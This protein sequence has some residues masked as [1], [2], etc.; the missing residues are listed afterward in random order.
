M[1]WHSHYAGES[2]PTASALYA[3]LF[4][5]TSTSSGLN[6]SLSLHF[7]LLHASLILFTWIQIQCIL[8]NNARHNDFRHNHTPNIR[9]QILSNMH[10]LPLAFSLY[11]LSVI[12]PSFSTYTWP[13]PQYDTLEGLLYEGRRSDGSSLAAL[14][15]PCRKRSGTLASV[16]A[17]WLRFVRFLHFVR[18]TLSNSDKLPNFLRLSMTWPLIMQTMVRAVWTVR[19]LMSSVVRR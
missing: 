13:S 10:G 15:H 18:L 4:L 3:T 1:L 8:I 19:L 7:S 5:P 12:T 2:S 17:E 9:N 14:V 16:P 6:H 11:V